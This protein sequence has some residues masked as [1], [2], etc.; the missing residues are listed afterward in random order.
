MNA[1][2]FGT[3]LS[4][5]MPR[6]TRQEESVHAPYSLGLVTI[7]WHEYQSP[8]HDVAKEHYSQIQP[9]NQ[10]AIRSLKVLY[11][12]RLARSTLNK[13]AKMVSLYESLCF[14]QAFWTHVNTDTIINCWKK[15]RLTKGEPHSHA[16]KEISDQ[17]P[18]EEVTL[19]YI[20]YC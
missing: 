13:E 20:Q 17:Q 18:A 14:V 3:W 11:R 12:G 19:S 9:Y 4:D 7:R 16:G 1:N 5:L 15:S 8:C 2:L 6:S 10:R